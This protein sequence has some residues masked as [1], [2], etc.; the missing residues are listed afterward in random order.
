MLTIVMYHYV[1]DLASSKYPKIHALGTDEFELQLDYIADAYEVVSLLDV[2]D[3]ATGGRSLPRDACLLTFDDGFADH[4]R[5][6][7]P[8]LSARA[9]PGAFFPPGLP[10]VERVLLDVHKLHFILA[11]A[12]DPSAVATSMLEQLDRMRRQRTL[13][14]E[15]QLRAAYECED[16][17]DTPEVMLIKGALQFGLPADVRTTLIRGLFDSFVG[18]DERELACELYMSTD[19][20]R[21]LVRE[22][23][24]VGGHGWTHAWLET[25]STAEQA[26]EIRRTLALLDRVYGSP[27]A[28]WTMCYPYGSYNPQTL[29]L[30]RRYGAAVGLTTRPDVVRDLQRPLELARLDTNDLPP[31]AAW[32]ATSRPAEDPAHAAVTPVVERDA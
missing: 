9:I 29:V 28:G 6:V 31:K 26:E 27:Q 25:L 2:V 16:R 18:E 32:P 19:Q 20:L 13:P 10:L 5:N 1:R 12:S 17:F 30:L 14:S 15:R 7:L 23:M 11:A 24:D 4:H 22:G 3:A 8:R 21:K